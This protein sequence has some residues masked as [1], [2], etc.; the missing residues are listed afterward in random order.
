M[1]KLLLGTILSGLCALTLS[2]NSSMAKSIDDVEN[3]VELTYRTIGVLSGI[4]VGVP[5]STML[6]MPDSIARGVDSIAREFNQGD[7]PDETQYV[8]AAVPGLVVGITDGLVRGIANGFENGVDKGFDRPFS[9]E[10]FSIS[11]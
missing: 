11:E 8:A 6:Q 2:T 7:T 4:T 9:L 1:K 3:P 10:S 5:I